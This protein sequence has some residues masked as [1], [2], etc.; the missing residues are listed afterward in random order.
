MQGNQK[1][2]LIGGIKL[3]VHEAGN[4]A[5]FANGLIAEEDELVLGER[6]N[7]RHGGNMAIA[8]KNQRKVAE[9]DRIDL[10]PGKE[11]SGGKKNQ[12]RVSLRGF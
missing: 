7:R 1:D 10:K 8:K 3:V 12:D 6:R 2:D 9:E 5:G 4:N 11:N